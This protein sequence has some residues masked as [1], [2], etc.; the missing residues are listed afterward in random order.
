[1][2]RR[3]EAVWRIF[4]GRDHHQWKYWIQ[5]G[6]MSLGW[7]QD[8][9]ISLSD[10]GSLQELQEYFAPR[11][12]TKSRGR[13]AARALWR[14]AVEAR[15]GDLVC[16]YDEGCILGIGEIV[17]DYEFVND[18]MTRHGNL[19]AW[20]RDV[21]WLTTSRR[22]LSP[23]QAKSLCKRYEWSMLRIEEEDIVNSI[24][25]WAHEDAEKEERPSHLTQAVA[26]EEEDCSEEER[27][28][29][30]K[31]A[32]R[33]NQARARNF[34]EANHHCCQVCGESINLPDGRKYVE[35]HHIQP[36]GEPHNGRDRMANMICLCPNHH[37]EMDWG[38]FYIDPQSK[39]VMHS[40]T[41]SN[42]KGARITSVRDNWPAVQ[43]LR[44]H[45]NTI[46]QEWVTRNR[47]R[48]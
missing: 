23:S 44:Y 11:Y 17:G 45:R 40:D 10:F 39:R 3:T 19:C 31:S 6:V 7:G 42:I 14:F 47:P 13:L 33:R 18:E 12:S 24:C 21:D 20:R 9:G 1:M 30:T 4:A 2:V 28:R 35:V 15:C 36:L 34:R 29:I 25:Q 46:C 37:A 48:I 41:H 16:V 27:Q 22:R 38:V 8:V 43:Y 5:C 26:V 32:V